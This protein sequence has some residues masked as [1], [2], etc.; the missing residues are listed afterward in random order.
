MSILDTAL[1]L[2]APHICVVCGAEGAVLCKPCALSLPTLPSICYV[3]AKATKNYAACSDHHHKNSPSS[4][5]IA[6]EYAGAIKQTIAAYKFDN[7][8]AAAKDI[9]FYLYNSLPHVPS[10]YIITYVPATGGH[11][12]QRGFNHV[13]LVAKVLAQLTGLHYNELLYRVTT[14]TQKGADKKTRKQQLAGAFG[15][16]GKITAGKKVLLVDDVI[17][18]GATIDAC[19]QQLRAAGANDVM[20][21]IAARTPLT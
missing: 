1:S 12:R 17:T 9:A 7:K 19:T 15:C 10:D 14:T 2:V 3:C 11:V 18:T 21:A 8:R 20:A 5:F 4:V 6:G 16:F 13:K